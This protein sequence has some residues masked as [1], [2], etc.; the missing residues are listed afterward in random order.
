[1]NK[2]ITLNAVESVTVL[3]P[4]TARISARNIA[5]ISVPH[6]LTSEI[7]HEVNFANPAPEPDRVFVER[8]TVM[9]S[10]LLTALTPQPLPFL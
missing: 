1:V 10:S 6:L 2:A 5:L 8:R 9:K 7:A 3:S 4:K